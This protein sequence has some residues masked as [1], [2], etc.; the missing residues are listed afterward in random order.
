MLLASVAFL[1]VPAQS[2]A[3]AANDNL[4]APPAGI[5]SKCNPVGYH[6]FGPVRDF[7]GDPYSRTRGQCVWWA[8]IQRLDERFVGMGTYAYQWAANAPKHGFKTGTVPQVGATVVFQ[9]GVAGAS[10]VGGHVAHVEVVYSG[11]WFLVSEMNFYA[12]GGG[13]DRVSYRYVHVG[14]GIS[15]IY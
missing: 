4:P 8:A 3:A 7:A 11:G 6:A 9:R 15:F 5:C 14:P 10:W 2:A 13:W 12:H 1:I